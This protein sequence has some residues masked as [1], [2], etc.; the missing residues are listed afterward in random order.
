MEKI[1]FLENVNDMIHSQERQLSP[2]QTQHLV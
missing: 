2:M 1:D